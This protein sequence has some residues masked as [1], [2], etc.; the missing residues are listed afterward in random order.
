MSTDAIDSASSAQ[1]EDKPFKPVTE[2]DKAV[3]SK[4]MG[5]YKAARLAERTGKDTP[6]TDAD[7]A[8]AQPVEQAVSTEASSSSAS[9]ADKPEGHKGNLKTRQAELDA[10]VA[11]LQ[12]TLKIRRQLRDELAALSV[13]P[14]VKPASQPAGAQTTQSAT[15]DPK[16]EDFA[17]EP[18][19]YAAW[20]E[21]RTK[22]LIAQTLESERAKAQQ[23]AAQQAFTT[24]SE[25]FKQRIAEAHAASHRY[26]P[27]N[28]H[29]PAL[30]RLRWLQ[31]AR[32]SRRECCK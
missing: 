22:N 17:N 29:R 31:V 24:R 7:A 21:A 9:E 32:G 25:T 13:D 2:A 1:T 3:V 6:K 8:P 14:T 11:K 18:D 23:T 19:P 5:G 26:T 27:A 4:D 20:M 12:D 28:C 16:I 15:A 30:D 10:D